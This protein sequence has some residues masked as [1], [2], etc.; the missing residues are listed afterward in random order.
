M[1]R[2]A[3]VS[4]NNRTLR[5]GQPI[6]QIAN[7]ANS[8]IY[9]LTLEKSLEFFRRS[10]ASAWT[11]KATSSRDLRTVTRMQ[12]PGISVPHITHS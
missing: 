3:L 8:G 2:A 6:L 12:S 9:L 7:T 1:L 10:L 11:G 4:V 5:I